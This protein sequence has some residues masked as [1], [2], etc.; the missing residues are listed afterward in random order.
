[1]W[2]RRNQKTKPTQQEI[3][4]MIFSNVRLPDAVRIALE[5]N[6][7]VIFAGAGIS[8]PPPSNL[9]SF[10]GLACEICGLESVTLGKEDQVLGKWKR[11]GTDVHLVAA[12]RLYNSQTHPTEAHKQILRIFGAADKVRI[13]TTNFD[14]HFS[15]AARSVF[16]KGTVNEFHA[17]ALPLGDDFEGIIYMHGSAKVK[18]HAMVLTDKDFGEAYLTRGWARD[19]LIPL[20][21]KYTVLFVGYSHNDVTISYLA[22][23]LN[24]TDLK[25]WALVS[26]DLKSEDNE[27]WARLEID[28]QQYPIDPVNTQNKHQALTNFF[29][30]WAKH[31][32]E[33]IL[34]RS[35]RI[36]SIAAGLPPESEAVSEYLDYCIRHPQLAQ[37][38]YN[39]I[40]H[41]AWI[42]W[43]NAKGYFKVFFSHSTNEFQIHERVSA[44]WLSSFV[45]KNHPELFLEI[46]QNNQRQPNS[47]FTHIFGHAIWVDDKKSPDPRFST[48]VAFLIS[49]GEQALPHERWA[50]LLQN[51]RI[52]EHTGIALRLFEFITTPRLRL[53]K[54]FDF[55]ALLSNGKK[56]KKTSISPKKVDCEIDWPESAK[57]WLAEA[58]K[59]IF[60]PNIHLLADPLALIAT[61][62]LTLASLLLRGEKTPNDTFDVFSW[63][64]SSIM[65]HEQNHDD[66][67][68]CLSTLIDIARDVLD[69]WFKTDPSRAHA[70]LEAWWSLNTPL[71]KRMT[72]YGIGGSPT[73]NAEDKLEWVLTNDLIFIY[74]MKKEVFDILATAYP[75]ASKEVKKKVIKR[76]ERGYP[77]SIKKKLGA[78]TSAYE[79]FNALVWLRRADNQCVY[80]EGA[81]EKIK[82]VHPNFAERDHPAFD[83]WMDGGGGFVDPKEGFDF[84]KI[85]AEPPSFYLDALSKAA[86]NSVRRDRW[87]YLSNLKPLITQNQKWG[88]GFMEALAKTGNADAEIWSSVFW[89]WR[90]LIVNNNDWKLIL[91]AIE[92]LPEERAVFAGIANLIS[93]G[94]FKGELDEKIITRAAVFMDK[95]WNICSKVEEMPDD[96]Y[97]DWLTSAINHEG[98]SIGEFWVHYCSH[99]REKA[100]AEWKGI[101]TTLKSKMQDALKGKS[102]IKVYARIVMTQWM[103]YFFAWDK[104]FAVENFLPLLDWQ[105]DPIVAQQTWSVLLNYRQGT[106]VEL[107]Q[108]MLPYYRQSAERMT[109]MLKGTTEKTEQFSEHALQNL[110]HYL[111]GL[112]IW[113]I[114]NPIQVGFFRDFL[115]PL[116]EKVRGAL[117]RGIGNFLESMPTEKAKEIWDAWLKE[118]LDLRL[119]GVP[120][121][122]SVEE[123]NAIAHWCPYLGN[124]FPEAVQRLMLMPLK[125]VNAYG[126]IDKLLKDPQN[127]LLERFPKESCN[128]IIAVLK[129]EEY[130]FL[131]EKH[132]QLH[133]KFKQTIPSTL[134]LR[135][136]E[137]LLYL[138]GWKK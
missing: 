41:P 99:L 60:K 104:D 59:N 68:E 25:R 40:R 45:R 71:L 76:I 32:K 1:M 78:D 129:G 106:S 4:L 70:Q 113:V 111:A 134:E 65:P 124:A 67:H 127:S 21:Q 66:F 72:A 89:I 69:F 48:W 7:L 51:C 123:T 20:F 90:E 22:R 110:G 101:P 114:P 85:L 14:N 42:G 13:V 121:A 75:K 5:N 130:P 112:A 122:L 138:R 15:D 132:S 37:D 82:K 87:S 35:K 136:F 73:M 131:D 86:S 100:G 61:K 128:Y 125:G 97:N 96:N 107:E 57:H 64:R 77:R 12:R 16:R 52:P 55:P 8:M 44:H 3:K 29:N 36:K 53:K 115:P 126:I 116:P 94:I 135:N 54:H 93:N 56:N 31:V 19:F 91:D 118:Y 2:W 105:R 49:Q 62:Q 9:P 133:N 109:I 102:S 17:P 30:G 92:N 120:V 80:I 98:G 6:T 58:W 103:R 83:R 38:F 11:N 24:S 81:I 84:G 43:L 18:P 74:G 28:V 10:N 88:Y 47:S 119:I 33:S 50:Y 26:S 117:N 95:A 137:E 79:Q 108:H 39:A 46:I 34:H 27:N 63:H 23:G